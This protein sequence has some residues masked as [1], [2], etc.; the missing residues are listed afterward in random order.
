V[1]DRLRAG[2]LRDFQYAGVKQQAVIMLWLTYAAIAAL[3]LVLLGW[4]LEYR[5]TACSPSRCC[6]R[7]GQACC[8]VPYALW[9]LVIIETVALASEEAHEPQVSIPRG[10]VLAQITLVVLVL[11]TW[12]FAAAAG[13]LCRNRGGGL[14][15]ARWCSKRS[16]HRMVF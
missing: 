9:W 8:A 3:G 16:G 10:L 15:T 5:S 11:L 13:A 4:R 6:H 2:F 1:R 14:S 12:F 7:A